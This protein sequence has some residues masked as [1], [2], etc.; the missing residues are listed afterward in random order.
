MRQPGPRGFK[1]GDVFA[2]FSPNVLIPI[3]FTASRDRRK[4]TT[5]HPLY[6][7]DELLFSCRIRREISAHHSHSSTKL[8]SG[9][10]TGVEEVSLWRSG[11]RDPLRLAPRSDG[12]VPEFHRPAQRLRAS[13]SSGTTGMPKCVML[14]HYNLVANCCQANGV[15]NLTEDEVL[16][17]VLPFFHIYGM[18]VILNMGLH[19][20][21]TIVSMP[22]FDLEQFLDI[23]QKYAVTR[24]YLVPPIVLALA[25]HPL[26]DDYD[27][28]NLKLVNSGAAPLGKEWP[29]LRRRI[30]LRQAWLRL[31]ETIPS[32]M[33]PATR[34]IKPGAS[35]HA[36]QHGIEVVARQVEALGP[37]AG[38]SD[39]R[40]QL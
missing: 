23:M 14:T 26:V 40:P 35:G 37:P 9:K 16:I 34:A 31:T 6:T 24:A 25:K 38:G 32:P 5:V 30:G 28:S 29:R 3:A 8:G 15:E 33:S 20:N 4:N 19:K 27:L 17:G 13:Y 7:A 2:I 1:K 12:E 22:R 21:Q 39:S 18:V 11:R 36:P 10:K